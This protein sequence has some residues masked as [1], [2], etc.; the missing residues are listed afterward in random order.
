MNPK[1]P[2]SEILKKYLADQCSEQERAMVDAWYQQLNSGAGEMFS[3]SDE[4]DLYERI[5]LQ[6]S[7]TEIVH[8]RPVLPL[9]K[10]RMYAAAA[11]VL[12]CLGFVYFF[13]QKKQTT[14]AGK[15]ALD[16]SWITFSN[17][18]KKI[19]RYALPDHSLVWLQ[20]GSAISHPVSFNTKTNREIRFHGEG[21]FDVTRD[22]KHPFI[23]NCGSLKTRVL[24]TSF[25]VKA[26]KNEATYKVS[27]VTGSVAVSTPNAE[28]KIQQV[29][30]KPEQQAVFEKATNNM[31]VNT[32]KNNKIN[33]ENW[34]S[35]SLVFNETPMSEVANRL[36]QTFR[37]KIEFANPHIKKCRLKVDFNNQ[38][39]PEI[40]EMIE[41]LLGTTYEI[42][43]D[44]VTLK[45]EG[46][47]N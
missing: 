20:P 22:V 14:L 13:L 1:L 17:D 4:E 43:G 18:K 8:N 30:L 33:N 26:N 32:V 29:V 2:S 6:I 12:L 35:V 47:K 45:G 44:K 11:A 15:T 36:Q 40:L 31:T 38:R 25:N 24:G 7:E 10:F 37:I 19:I 27:V 46:C 41:T 34:Q 39:L 21:F 23:I 9:R 3:S 16:S 5:Q 28:N 42:E